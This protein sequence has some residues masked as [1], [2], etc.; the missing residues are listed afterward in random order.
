M[1]TLA[2]CQLPIFLP[3]HFGYNPFRYVPEESA[4]R[5][6]A[7]VGKFFAQRA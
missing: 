5:V 4:H 2:L 3:E 6:L 1:L 7:S